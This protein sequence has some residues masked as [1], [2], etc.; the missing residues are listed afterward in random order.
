MGLDECLLKGVILVDHAVL[1]ITVLMSEMVKTKHIKTAVIL[2][3]GAGTRLRSVVKNVPKPLAPVNGRPFLEYVL[4]QLSD[5][6]I[7]KVVLCTGYMAP[8]VR[9]TLGDSYRDLSLEYSIEQEALGTAGALTNASRLLGTERVLIMNGDSYCDIDLAAFDGF[10]TDTNAR[11][12]IALTTVEDAGR[13]GAVSVDE[14]NVITAFREK[15]P[16]TGPGWINSGIYILGEHVMDSLPSTTP[17]SL[18]RDVFPGMIGNG[19][20]GWCGGGRFIDIGIPEDY[21]RA[22]EF[23]SAVN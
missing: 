10:H 2:V 4:D 6:G 3:G 20:A 7:E 13:Y 1:K 8:L 15:D 18:E 16:S 23:F 12:S 5:H 11:I 19:L 14:N 22:P 17:L 21:A 9:E